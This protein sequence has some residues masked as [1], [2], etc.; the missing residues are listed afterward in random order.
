LKTQVSKD[1]AAI[2][3]SPPGNTSFKKDGAAVEVSFLGNTSSKDGAAV[4]VSPHGNNSFTGWRWSQVESS[5]KHKFQKMALQSRFSCGFL[6]T[7]VLSKGFTG[8]S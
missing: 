7:E 4:E 3:V 1:G 8:K 5:W 2:D 6:E